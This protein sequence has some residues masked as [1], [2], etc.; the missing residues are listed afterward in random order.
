MTLLGGS[1]LRRPRMFNK[2]LSFGR[3]PYISPFGGFRHRLSGQFK[4][5][6]LFGGVMIKGEV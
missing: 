6:F 5:T 3:A 4:R 2:Q 1:K